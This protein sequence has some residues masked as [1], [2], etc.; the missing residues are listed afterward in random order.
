M[1]STSHRVG[2]NKYGASGERRGTG[3]KQGNSTI[4]RKTM[5][6]GMMGGLMMGFM[7]MWM[8]FFGGFRMFPR[9]L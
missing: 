5:G 3:D 1:A 8:M 6:M 4:R 2:G 7:A 9:I